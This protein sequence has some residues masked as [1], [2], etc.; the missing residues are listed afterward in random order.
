MDGLLGG[1]ERGGVE[2]LDGW[3]DGCILVGPLRME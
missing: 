2:C 3:R 1:G